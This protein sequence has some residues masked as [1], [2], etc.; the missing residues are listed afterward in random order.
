MKNSSHKPESNIDENEWFILRS[1]E[2]F[3]DK[4]PPISIS[5]VWSYWYLNPNS[6]I[7][8]PPRLDNNKIQVNIYMK[9]EIDLSVRAYLSPIFVSDTNHLESLLDEIAVLADS[10]EMSLACTSKDTHI[11]SAGI[12]IQQVID[13]ISDNKLDEEFHNCPKIS[14]LHNLFIANFKTL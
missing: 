12:Y 3:Q 13:H 1:F 9:V 8:M 4:L 6:L 10:S 7:F 11:P 2:E 5:N 14:K